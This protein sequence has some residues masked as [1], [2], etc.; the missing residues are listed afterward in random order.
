MSGP[1]VV[2]FCGEYSTKNLDYL[3]CRASY[4]RRFKPL[5]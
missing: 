3:G 2:G 1:H 5:G 4:F